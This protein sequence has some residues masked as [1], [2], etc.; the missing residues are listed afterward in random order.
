MI[1]PLSAL[2]SPAGLSATLYP[3]NSRYAGVPIATLTARNGRTIPYLRRRFVPAP[4][5]FAAM[6]EYMVAQGDRLDT[7]AASQLGDPE[8]FW[9]L[10]DANRAL[11]PSELLSRIGRRL[12]ITLP[13]GMVGP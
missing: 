8:L 7:I 10:C 13:E 2:L 1:D 12:R 5:R 9:R 4:E 11:D 6:R 3:A